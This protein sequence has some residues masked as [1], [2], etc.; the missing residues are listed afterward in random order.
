MHGDASNP[1]YRYMYLRYVAR[2]PAA[3]A[4]KVSGPRG[5]RMRMIDHVFPIPL[6]KLDEL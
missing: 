4:A 1:I 2:R 3:G 6:A 5:R